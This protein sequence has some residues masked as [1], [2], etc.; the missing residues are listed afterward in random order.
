MLMMC[1]RFRRFTTSNA[2]MVEYERMVLQNLNY[3]V[4][5]SLCFQSR[6]VG[7]PLQ[8]MQNSPETIIIIYIY[9]IYNLFIDL[10]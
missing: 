6:N 5:I 2:C 7:P 4:D 9:Y 10:M 1:D 8:W 3:F